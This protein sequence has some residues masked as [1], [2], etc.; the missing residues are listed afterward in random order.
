MDKIIEKNFPNSLFGADK[1]KYDAMQEI[2]N[3][4]FKEDDYEHRLTKEA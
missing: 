2:I 4:L 1:G 3:E